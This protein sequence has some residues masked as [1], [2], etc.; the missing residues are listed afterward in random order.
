MRMETGKEIGTAGYGARVGKEA[1]RIWK[2]LKFKHA[3]HGHGAESRGVTRDEKRGEERG[4]VCRVP[5]P[6]GR[7]YCCR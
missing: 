2:P 1:V 4:A 3:S 6:I 5:M 7:T